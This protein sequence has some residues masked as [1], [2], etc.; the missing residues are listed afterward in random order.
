MQFEQGLEQPQLSGAVLNL[1]AL[2][3]V[4]EAGQQRGELVAAPAAQL[5]ERRMLLAH[6]RAQR[7]EQRRVGKLGLALLDALAAQRDRAPRAAQ[8][9]LELADQARLADPES[10]PTSTTTGRR[11][12]ASRQASSSSASSPTRPT[13]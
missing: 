11:S 1:G 9:L 13:K 12:A 4:V 10:P 6:Q 5:L 2:A 7:A 3:P 8:P